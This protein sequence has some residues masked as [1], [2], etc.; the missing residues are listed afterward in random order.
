M[1]IQILGYS[2]SIKSFDINVS[3]ISYHMSSIIIN[4][5]G[6]GHIFSKIAKK[7][8]QTVDGVS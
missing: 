2:P 7:C 8:M 6:R 1:N 4:V 5:W 3:E